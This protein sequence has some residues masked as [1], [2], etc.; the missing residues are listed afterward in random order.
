LLD[1][2]G[3]VVGTRDVPIGPL[4]GGASMTFSVKVDSPKAVAYRYAPVK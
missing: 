3:A 2:T 4:D 1:E